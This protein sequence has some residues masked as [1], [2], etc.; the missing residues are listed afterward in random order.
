MTRSRRFAIKKHEIV[1]KWKVMQKWMDGEKLRLIIGRAFVVACA[2]QEL[3]L[4]V[5]MTLNIIDEVCPLAEYVTM[6]HKWEMLKRI[7]HFKDER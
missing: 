4:P 5:L 7:K 1:R 2:M 6:Y 3:E